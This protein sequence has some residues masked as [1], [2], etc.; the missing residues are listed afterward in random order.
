VSADRLSL[1]AMIAAGLMLAHQVAGKAVR[2]SFFLSQYPAADLPRMVIAAAS[3]TIV[4][5]LLFA[6]ALSRFGPRRLV[7]AGFLASA[8]IHVG[9]YALSPGSPGPWSVVIYF[10][11][12]ALGAILLSGFWS[13]ITEAFDPRSAK[14]V[15]ARITGAGTLGGI[16]GGV[17]AERTA[18]MLSPTHVLLLLA[19]LHLLCSAFLTAVR[20]ASE[21]R[22]P[23]VESDPVSPRD[24]FRR[25]PYLRTIAILVLSGT[26]AA[27]VLD[28]M[29]KAGA[30]LTFGKG[31]PL[32]RFFAV[33]YTS[34]Q[35]LTF[36]SQAFLARPSLRRLG[37]GKTVAALP[38]TVGA[39]A[40]G[41]LFVPAFP[42]ILSA[43]A[44]E[45]L[46][47]GSLFRSGYELLFTP[48][49]PAEKRAAKTLIDVGCDRAGDA[50]GSG[51]VQLLLWLGPAYVTSEYLGATLALAAVGV[52][53]AL[54]LDRQYA[55]LVRQRLV[56]RAVELDLAESVES[57]RLPA[58]PSLTVAVATPAP[59]APAPTPPAPAAAPRPP[60]QND[61]LIEA[62]Q[63]LRSG[64]PERVRAALE[65]LEK[66]RPVIAAQ[67]VRLLAW[68][69]VSD[70]ARQALM[71]CPDH[72]TGLLADHLAMRNEVQFGI[73]RRIPRILSHCDSQLAVWGLLAGLRD[74]RFEV[75]FQCSRALD[76]LL[77]RNPELH[78]DRDEV[79]AAVERE[80]QVA[81][82]IWDSRR[83]LDPRDES[84]PYAFFDEHLRER[85]D[86]SLEHIFSL[87]ATVLPRE[88]AKIAFRALHTQDPVL[89][90]LAFEYLEGVL[91]PTVRERLWPIIEPGP[92]TAPPRPR[93]E[94]VAD[95]VRS[96]ESLLMLLHPPT[97]E[98]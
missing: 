3:L 87:F 36:L 66:P 7:P 12:V 19:S 11:I 70:A 95:L 17:L 52:W 77:Q 86:R 27:A 57:I 98:P 75:R 62:L 26:A 13:V 40:L 37:I 84:D 53:G 64:D 34:T 47:R 18:A 59:P 5:V 73:R 51:V 89:R 20:S 94:V 2:D 9:E 60:V 22:H 82:P 90:N 80:L 79:F 61:S 93:E 46:M 8:A 72:F 31:A 92:L 10:H 97:A 43:R 67:V 58:A 76:A 24:L 45:F 88:P 6:R 32:L 30:G 55:E 23:E 81:R 85:A 14:R 49:P 65:K 4:F 69:E 63:Q 91:P 71:R 16:V 50:L 44:G 48:V 78:A 41:A 38:A 28:Y 21:G 33:F 1:T 29:F 56:D 68:D 25:A 96:H 39:G 74:V 35:V 42:A 54:R 15:F 83:L